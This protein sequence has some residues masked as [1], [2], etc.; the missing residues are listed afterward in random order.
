MTF[1]VAGCSCPADIADLHPSFVE[2]A[3]LVAATERQFVADMWDIVKGLDP[4][5]KS[6]KAWDCDPI[7]RKALLARIDSTDALHQAARMLVI[8]AANEISLPL[9]RRLCEEKTAFV[10][11]VFETPLRLYSIILKRIISE[12][13]DVSKPGRPNWIWDIQVSLST[14]PVGRLQGLPIWL[15]TDDRAILQAS[16]EG[17]TRHLI[18]R[19]NEYF[20][21]LEG[22][23]AKF[24]KAVATS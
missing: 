17:G 11:R 12:R 15:I 6:W 20:A 2:I 23:A 22:P 13:C 18:H 24:D 1:R 16:R 19:P 21:L 9:D 14:S 3:E 4:A 5:A 8:K 10:V 7:Q